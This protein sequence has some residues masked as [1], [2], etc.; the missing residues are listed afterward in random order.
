MITLKAEKDAPCNHYHSKTRA[1]TKTVEV[2]LEITCLKL[3][4]TSTSTFGR[5]KSVKFEL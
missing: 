3:S 1:P 5:V 4:H 2:I